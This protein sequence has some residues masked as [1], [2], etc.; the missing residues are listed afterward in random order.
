VAD[1]GIKEVGASTYV[2]LTIQLEGIRQ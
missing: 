1:F 2:D